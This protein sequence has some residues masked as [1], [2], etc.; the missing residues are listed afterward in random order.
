MQIY[1]P[2]AELSVDVFVLLILGWFVGFI[3]GISGIGASF[4]MTPTLIFLGIPSPVAVASQANQVVAT[5]ISG[6][7]AQWSRGNIDF[8]MGGILLLGG[9]A[10]SSFGVWLFGFLARIG[11]GDLVVAISYIMCLGWIG[12]LMLWESLRSVFKKLQASAKVKI[13]FYQRA[14]VQGLP[15]KRNFPRSNLYISLW[16]PIVIGFGVGV[17]SAIMGVGG[18][19][20]LVP[21]MIYLLGMPV[22]V[23][24]GTS[25]F[26]MVFVTAN[27]T[28]QQAIQN[29]SVDILLALILMISGVAGTQ[30]GTKM[31]GK[32]RGEYVR[33]VFALLML[34]VCVG[35]IN[36][37]LVEPSSVYSIRTVGE[38]R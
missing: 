6:T 33:F 2:I 9:L 32:V 20:L 7:L 15:F 19:F 17:L 13:P 26:Q 37:F 35:L 38:L 28:L 5:S 24:V 36:E 25:L 34:G 3:S 30:W 23:V 14:W 16:L 18:S 22:T 4:L 27:V 1:L 10:G 8:K 12:L 11:Q 21:A 31:S 29:N